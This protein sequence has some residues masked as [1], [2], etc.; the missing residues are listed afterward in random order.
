MTEENKPQEIQ[1]QEIQPQEIQPQEIK[2]KRIKTG[3]RVKKETIGP[4]QKREYAPAKKV[5][6][7]V[8]ECGG[9]YKTRSADI[10]HHKNTKK[11]INFMNNFTINVV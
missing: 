5:I 3:G 10:N 2:P 4:Y 7:M 8:C 6:D 9:R 11:H 1:P